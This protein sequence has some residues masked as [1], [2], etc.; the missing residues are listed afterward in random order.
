MPLFAT[1]EALVR[2]AFRI[3]GRAVSA[4]H[5][6]GGLGYL[7]AIATGLGVATLR[8]LSL[9]WTLA[10]VSLATLSFFMVAL[11]T[12]VLTGEE[13]LT[14]YH[15]E[16]AILVG[17]AIL[18]VTFDQPLLPYLDLS[19]LSVGTFLIF[20]RVGCLFVGCCHGAPHR[21]GIRYGAFHA[22]EGFPSCLVGVP[23][24]PVQLIESVWVL[25]TVGAG[26]YLVLS[27]APAGSVLAF[28]TCCYG[29]ARFSIEY[30]RGDAS[31]AYLWS[32]SEAQ[33]TTLVV[34]AGMAFAELRGWLPVVP[35][36]LGATAL[37][38]GA[39][40]ASIFTDG[41]KRRLFRGEHIHQ[42]AEL[43][44]ALEVESQ[45]R[46][47]ICMGRTRIGLQLSAS[48]IDDA[49]GTVVFAFSIE[50]EP[51]EQPQIERLARLIVQLSGKTLASD[52]V[53]GSAGVSHLVLRATSN[54]I[55]A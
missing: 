34:M 43:M 27:H 55:A 24:L 10:L 5:L 17:A 38:G 37:V 7:S 49:R 18:L 54:R 20:G 1:L 15:H 25:S 6:W 48:P 51:L 28:Y 3:R 14:F 50:G 12:K 45:Q 44:R 46:G 9:G 31:R 42:L 40:L 29:L 36:H 39:A 8:G 53:T 21:L 19:A 11:V 26:W 4:F 32:L 52:V 22:H 13:R 16:L 35:W 23:L 30:L 33:W 41:S 2:P 47:G